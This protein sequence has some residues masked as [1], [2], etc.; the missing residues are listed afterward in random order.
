MTF[1]PVVRNVKNT[2][3][4]FFF[5]LT[6]LAILIEGILGLILFFA[7]LGYSVFNKT[8]LFKWGYDAFAGTSIFVMLILQL[9]LYSGL[10]FSGAQLL[11]RKKSGFYLFSLSYLLLAGTNY[12]IQNEF[13][14]TGVVIGIIVWLILLLNYK[15]LD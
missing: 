14:M 1:E 12:F 3:L 5:R 13:S 11:R 2:G 15:I 9:V 4:P 7:V 10:T 6:S 8:F